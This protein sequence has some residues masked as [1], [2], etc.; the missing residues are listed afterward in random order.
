MSKKKSSKAVSDQQKP[1]QPEQGTPV[2]EGKPT[3]EA[4][5][6]GTASTEL[7]PAPE[8][9][10]EQIPNPPKKL[11][12]SDVLRELDILKQM[13]SH[14]TQQLAEIET[15]L[16]KPL[17]SIS[18]ASRTKIQIRDKQTGVVYPSQNN[19]YKTLLKN[20]DLKELVNKGIFGS[21]PEKNSY[22]WFALK[23]AW[24]DRFEEVREV[25]TEN[26]ETTAST[27]G[28][29]QDCEGSGGDDAAGD[30]LFQLSEKQIISTFYATEEGGNISHLCGL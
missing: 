9:A 18:P 19:A 30:G 17:K 5:P 26:T 8:P 13:V 1:E 25:K 7:T 20:G 22:G 21:E 16:T 11:T 6:E 29:D 3:G 14:H 27:P 23:R 24:P 2:D 10:K 28:T 12:L 15:R 4:Q